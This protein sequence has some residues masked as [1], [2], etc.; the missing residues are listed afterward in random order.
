[1]IPLEHIFSFYLRSP[2][3]WRICAKQ[4]TNVRKIGQMSF[5]SILVHLLLLLFINYISKAKHK[6][7]KCKSYVTDMVW[8]SFVL[9]SRGSLLIKSLITYFFSICVSFLWC[10]DSSMSKINMT[11][12]ACGSWTHRYHRFWAD[13]EYDRYLF[14]LFA[15]FVFQCR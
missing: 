1:M 9:R 5:V 14:P 15:V 3:P 4:S 10:V 13:I 11:I 12:K 8:E 7:N 6:E 2:F